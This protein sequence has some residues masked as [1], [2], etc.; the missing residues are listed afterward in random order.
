MV[1]AGDVV[2]AGAPLCVVEAMKS[3]RLHFDFLSCIEL[4][5]AI[6]TRRNSFCEHRKLVW[7]PA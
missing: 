2:D 5:T 7:C 1:K 3:V 6:P 4:L